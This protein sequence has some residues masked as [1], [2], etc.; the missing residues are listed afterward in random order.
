MER[1]ATSIQRRVDAFLKQCREAGMSATPQRIA[2]YRTLLLSEDHPTPEVLFQRVHPEMPS[3]SLATVYKVLDALTRLGLAQEV[4]VS[5]DSK[6][7]D[8]NMERHHHLI[9]TRCKKVLDYYAPQFD[10]IAAPKEIKGF[11][12]QEISVQVLGCCEECVKRKA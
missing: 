7:Y 11:F 6:R 3:L 5:S 4:P 8:A 9:C 12:A 1:T 10:A 2:I